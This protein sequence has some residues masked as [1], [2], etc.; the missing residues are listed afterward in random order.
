[1]LNN[2]IGLFGIGPI[3]WMGDKN[4]ALYSVIMAASWRH[5]AYCMII[6]LAGLKSVPADLIEAGKIDGVNKFQQYVHIVFPQLR[7]ATTV[8]ITTTL[9]S[10]FTIFDVVFAMTKGGP[11]GASDVIGS[12]MYQEAFWNLKFGEA[13]AISYVM[14]VIVALVTIPYCTKQIRKSEEEM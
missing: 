10:S 5:I 3:N 7:P 2:I 1:L 9:V 6:Y 4:L 13:S 8:I 11:N 12:R 14:F